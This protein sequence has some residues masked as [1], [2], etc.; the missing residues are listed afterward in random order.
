MHWEHLYTYSMIILTQIHSHIGYAYLVMKPICLSKFPPKCRGQGK[1][2]REK[3]CNQVLW[4][5]L[6]IYTYIGQICGQSSW[7]TAT[8]ASIFKVQVFQ[9][10]VSVGMEI[11]HYPPPRS[12]ITYN[13]LQC[14]SSCLLASPGK[15][16]QLSFQKMKFLRP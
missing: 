7:Q 9:V 10:Y 12:K 5:I 4:L 13:L 8:S 2:E 6:A 14:R 16:R 15:Q 1:V 3:A 11:P